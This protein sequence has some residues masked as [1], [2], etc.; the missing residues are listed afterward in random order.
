MVAFDVDLFFF[1]GDVDGSGSISEDVD[2]GGTHLA[3]A[4]DAGD[5]GDPLEGEAH[6]VED[7]GE[8][9]KAC[10]G[11]TGSIRNPN[12]SN[13]RIIPRHLQEAAG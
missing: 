2:D 3:E 1:F 7:D 8:H 11:N 13:A 4:V 12:K 10:A 9:D 5:E 6:G